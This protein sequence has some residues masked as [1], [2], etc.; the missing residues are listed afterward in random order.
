MIIAI[1]GV[2]LLFIAIG[3]AVTEKSAKYLLAGYNTM[4]KEDRD[5]LSLKSYLP[6]FRRFHIYLGVSLLSIGLI[7]ILLTNESVAGVFL[8]VYPVLAYIY[9]IGSSNKTTTR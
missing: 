9:F 1:V 7:L 3:L 4:S 6:L 5:K 2:S 8:G